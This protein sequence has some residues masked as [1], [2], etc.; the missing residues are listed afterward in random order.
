V[1]SHV[2]FSKS[3]Q[4]A[5]HENRKMGPKAVVLCR[6]S[7]KLTMGLVVYWNNIN[8]FFDLIC[9]QFKLSLSYNIQ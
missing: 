8:V 1:S 2:E 9:V 3:E 5:S 4:E 6:K 7:V